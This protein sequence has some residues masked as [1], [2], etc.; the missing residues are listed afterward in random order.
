MLIIGFQTT[1]SRSENEYGNYMIRSEIGHGLGELG[2]TLP[3]KNLKRALP[4]LLLFEVYRAPLGKV[5]HA[6]S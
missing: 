3:P 5:R 1:K 2:G 6:I 4:R